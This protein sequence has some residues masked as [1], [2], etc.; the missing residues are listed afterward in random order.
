MECLLCMLKAEQ[1]IEN[2]LVLETKAQERFII[3]LSI[4]FVSKCF[5]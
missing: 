3:G 4:Y 5:H 2:Y 1:A